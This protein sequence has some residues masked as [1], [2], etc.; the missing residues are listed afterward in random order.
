M[1][2]F[3]L[4]YK[5]LDNKF[6]DHYCI[7]THTHMFTNTHI[8]TYILESES[9]KIIKW[10]ILS[11]ES[12]AWV[13]ISYSLMTISILDVLKGYRNQHM[14]WGIFTLL[15]Y[16]LLP[17]NSFGISFHEWHY[18][19]LRSWRQ[20]SA[21]NHIFFPLT[22]PVTYSVDVNIWIYIQSDSSF[23]CQTSLSWLDSLYLARNIA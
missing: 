23:N 3:H 2:P 12:P 22:H 4:E 21:F 6:C 5:G 9:W 11:W 19:L 7:H 14:Q 18:H 16:A 1:N 17:F 8:H 10:T 15:C 20:N 13:F